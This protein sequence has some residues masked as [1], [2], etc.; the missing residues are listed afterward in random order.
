LGIQGKAQFGPATY[1][2]AEK[3][4]PK[5]GINRPKTESCS[6]SVADGMIGGETAEQTGVGKWKERLG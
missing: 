6:G 5:K 1:A 2:A 3:K 4:K